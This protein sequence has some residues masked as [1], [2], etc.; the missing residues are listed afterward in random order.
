MAKL[1]K[2]AARGYGASH[3]AER[4][5]HRPDVDA[6]RAHCAEVICLMPTRWIQPGTPWDLAHNRATGGYLGPAHRWC[7]RAEGARWKQALAA[8]IT[9]PP[10]PRRANRWT[11]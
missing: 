5:R 9:R 7:N 8:G 1:R 2:T 11:L 3:Q 10:Q 6:G 4:E